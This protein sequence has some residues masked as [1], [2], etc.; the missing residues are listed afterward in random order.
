MAAVTIHSDFGA[1]ENKVCHCSHEIKR[2]L[3]LGRKAMTNLDSI[4]KSRDIS[5]QAMVCLG[6][7]VVMHGWWELDH[8]ED[9]VPKDWCFWNLVLEKTVESSLDS[10]GIKPVNPKGNQ[11]WIFVGRTDAEAPILWLLDA[12]GRLIGKDTDAGKDWGQEEKG[13]MEDDMAGWHH[14]LSGHEFE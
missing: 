8:K 13:E 5:L 2:H 11:P 7:S 3:L 14:R 6:F 10:K 4:L 1:Q 9:W 12:K